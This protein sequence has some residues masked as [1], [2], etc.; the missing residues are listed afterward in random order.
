MSACWSIG[1]CTGGRSA[2][3]TS[4]ISGS[5]HDRHAA[6]ACDC[7]RADQLG[8]VVG[9]ERRVVRS[10]ARLRLGDESSATSRRSISLDRG[11][12]A[13]AASAACCAISA[14]ISSGSSSSAIRLLGCAW[15]AKVGKYTSSATVLRV[16]SLIALMISSFAWARPS[17]VDEL[18]RGVRVDHVD[19]EVADLGP[20]LELRGLCGALGGGGLDRRLGCR[21]C[22]D[23]SSFANVQAARIGQVDEE[24]VAERDDRALDLLLEPLL[25]RRW[26]RAFIALVCACTGVSTGPPP[27]KNMVYAKNPPPAS[28]SPSTTGRSFLIMFVSLS[29]RISA[30]H[31]V[32]LGATEPKFGTAPAGVDPSG[33]IASD[34]G[35]LEVVDALHDDLDAA[36]A[37]A[38]AGLRIVRHQRLERAEALG[39]GVAVAL[40][41]RSRG[42]RGRTGRPRRG[43]RRGGRCRAGRCGTGRR[44]CA[45]RR[46]SG[47][48]RCCSR[49]SRPSVS[50]GNAAGRIVEEP[51]SNS[52][53]SVTSRITRPFELICVLTLS[54]RPSSRIFASTAA[55]ACS[56]VAGLRGLEALRLR[57]CACGR[58]RAGAAGSP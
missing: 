57:P 50:S 42:P 7:L 19:H 11:A 49:P 54:S 41:A 17:A 12:S 14:S 47:S 33:P 2:N 3:E 8:D 1:A 29:G 58:A 35:A 20:L 10:S 23:T 48:C 22:T 5:S 28:A 56:Q 39:R 6:T 25:L 45:L 9:R 53:L 46:G 15:I 4:S 51:R 34:S 44:P 40:D 36:V 16:F 52:T 26:R 27:A 32:I 37:R 21:P 38:G 18:R 31:G 43:R 55:L 24:R 13:P 30:D